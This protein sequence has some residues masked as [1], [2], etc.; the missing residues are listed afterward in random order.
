M[1]PETIREITPEMDPETMQGIAPEMALETIQGITPEMDPE[2]IQEITPE[3]TLEE[4]REIV[5]E[6]VPD[7]LREVQAYMGMHIRM[8]EKEKAVDGRNFQQDGYF[9]TQ[10]EERRKMN[11]VIFIMV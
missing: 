2:T 7:I 9:I 8:L 3:M 1:D 6:E 5:L 4:I 11:G 10:M